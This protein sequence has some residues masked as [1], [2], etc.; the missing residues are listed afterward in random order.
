MYRVSCKDLEQTAC[1]CLHV[2]GEKLLNNLEIKFIIL[3]GIKLEAGI[4]NLRL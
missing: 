2:S 4:I 3:I 1:M